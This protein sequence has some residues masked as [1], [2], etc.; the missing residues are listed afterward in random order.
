MFVLSRWIQKRRERRQLIKETEAREAERR[1]QREKRD[2]QQAQALLLTFYELQR[3]MD[4]LIATQ[5]YNNRFCPLTGRLPEELILGMLDFLSDDAVA[6]QCLR[7]VSRTFFRLLDYQSDFW[8]DEW[9]RNGPRSLDRTA[10]Y[11]HNV[12]R[13]QF[14]R[15]LQRDGR[16]DNCKRYN[17]RYAQ[18]SF[19]LF[20]H[21]K[22]QQRQFYRPGTNSALY[23]TCYCD[24]CYCLHDVCQFSSPW[25]YQPKR[26]CL[27]QQ[28]SVQL[29]EHVQITWASIEAHIDGWRRQQQRRGGDWQACLNSFNIECHDAS[30]DTRCT[31]SEVS[32]WPRARLRT[33]TLR[34]DIVAL[35]L[36]WIPHSRIDTLDLTTDGRIP[37]SEL[38]ALFQ[39]LRRLGPADT[40]YPPYRSGALPE[41]AYFSPSSPLGPFIYYKTGKDDKTGHPAS[42]PPLPSGYWPP[43][44][45]CYGLGKNGK[46]LM[47][48]PHYVRGAGGTGISFQCLVVSYEKDVMVC[49][50]S[51]MTD[52][53]V[54]IIPTNQWLHA[55]DTDTYPHPQAANIRPQCRDETCSN[56]YRRP[57]RYCTCSLWPDSHHVRR[58]S[59]SSK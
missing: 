25:K 6:L 56:Y 11:L 45:D 58:Y 35:S 2:N 43:L 13:L 4:P 19:A 1:T 28:G 40:L 37:A 17:D 9:Y 55:M 10:F 8:R 27:G 32:T 14:R 46:Q 31:V 38:R 44:W 21:C 15:L 59:S 23:G 36:E 52:P 20:D 49:K 51:A 39:R 34:P 54:K 12:Q 3:T 16:C 57:N 48:R 18:T 41:M 29:C 24:A 53:T 33:D 42:F 47:I 5:V 22:F 7:I 50:T 26:R 30:H